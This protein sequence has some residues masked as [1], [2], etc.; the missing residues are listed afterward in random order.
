MHFLTKAIALLFLATVVASTT[1]DISDDFELPEVH[2]IIIKDDASMTV[3]E[4]ARWAQGVHLGN[5]HYKADDVLGFM[6]IIGEHTYH[7]ITYKDTMD[8]IRKNSDVSTPAPYGFGPS[9]FVVLF[10]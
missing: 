4:H 9:Y 8:I 10:D 1:M 6:E 3:D 5:S 7:F 2:E